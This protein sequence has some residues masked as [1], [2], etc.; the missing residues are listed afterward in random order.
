[1]HVNITANTSRL[2]S[3]RI[4]GLTGRSMPVTVDDGSEPRDGASHLIIWQLLKDE[5]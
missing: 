4:I 5:G 3:I 2:G 1:M